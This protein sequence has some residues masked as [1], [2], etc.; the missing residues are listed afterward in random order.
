M[1]KENKT[2]ICTESDNSFQ[3]WERVIEVSESLIEQS[4]SRKTKNKLRLGVEWFRKMQSQ[5][6]PFPGSQTNSILNG[7]TH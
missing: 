5:S 3:M 2:Q 6:V 7:V 1:C 4:R